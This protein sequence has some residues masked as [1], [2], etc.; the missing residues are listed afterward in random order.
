MRRQ[1]SSLDAKVAGRCPQPTRDACLALDRGRRAGA[2]ARAVRAR[3]R[4][5]QRSRST[6]TATRSARCRGRRRRASRQVVDDEW[7]G[8]LIRSWNDAG[9]ITL[10]QRIGDKI[11]RAGRRGRRRGGRGRLDVGE[12]A[13]RCC[14]RRCDR[15]RGRAGARASCSPSARTSR[16]ISTSRTR[17]RAQHGL[18]LRL[19]DADDAGRRDRPS[20]TAVVL[21]THVELPHRPHARHGGGDAAPR[22]RPARS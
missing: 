19:V 4:G 13:T 8:G 20:D 2:A 7:G 10:P 3:R 21:L 5:C 12:P 16:P 6:S 22:T 17:W 15:R 11:A 1:L 9:W 14:R 18:E